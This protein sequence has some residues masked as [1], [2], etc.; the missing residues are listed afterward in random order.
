MGKRLSLPLSSLVAQDRG[1]VEETVRAKQ[2][3]FLFFVTYWRF[4]LYF[5]LRRGMRTLRGLLTST[6]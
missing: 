6:E 3:G 1:H 4:F 5:C 2:S